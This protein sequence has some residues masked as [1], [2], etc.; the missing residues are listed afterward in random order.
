MME[1][2]Q[3]G[4]DDFFRNHTIVIVGLGLMGGSLAMAMR[5]FCNRLIAVDL[6]QEVLQAAQNSGVID[7][8]SAILDDIVPEADLIVL[9]APVGAI[10]NVLEVLPNL[11]PRG[12]KVFDMGSTKSD[13]M[14]AMDRLPPRFDPLGGHPMCGKEKLS[15]FQAE[16][17][18]FHGAPFA[19]TPLSRTSNQWLNLAKI[20]CARIGAKP[21]IL[22]AAQH[23]SIVAATS[24]LPYLLSSALVQATSPEDKALIGPG[25]RGMAR[26]AATPPAMMLDVLLT[27]R[28]AILPALQALRAELGVLYEVLNGENVEYLKK[29]LS[30]SQQK[31]QM[32]LDNNNQKNIGQQATPHDQR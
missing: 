28:A 26:L 24:H 32:L 14:M 8:G 25:F 29:Y 1:E 17:G 15:Y 27:N 6:N 22:D 9:A 23:D 2:E 19:L 11:H 30:H 13:I 20:L 3:F 5:P 10:L 16:A 12:C 18:L 4:E 31:Q 21:V 7:R